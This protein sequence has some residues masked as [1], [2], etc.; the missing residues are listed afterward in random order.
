MNK[1]EFKEL[2]DD[3]G[4]TMYGA[5]YD[6]DFCEIELPSLEETIKKRLKQA[7]SKMFTSSKTRE[8]L[9]EHIN[10]MRKAY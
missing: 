5:S 4:K 1:Q 3:I 10:Q 6:G 8:E 9:I 2:I 7:V